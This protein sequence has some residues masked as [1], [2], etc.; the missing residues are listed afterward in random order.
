M[1]NVLVMGEYIID[2]S[3]KIDID[4]ILGEYISKDDLERIET[5][6]KFIIKLW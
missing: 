5:E 1:H 6:T 2:S 4:K 3:T